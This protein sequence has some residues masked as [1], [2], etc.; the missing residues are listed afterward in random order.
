[1]SHRVAILGSGIGAQ[2]LDGYLA[3]P[4]R[5]TV[6]HV[7]DLN[8][9]L[10]RA[11]AARVPG[12]V[13]SQ[14]IAA[15]LADPAVEIVD[16]C[17]PP[18]MHVPVTC[19]ALAAGKHV[20]CEKP[21]AGSVA[22]ADR[23]QQ[24]ASRSAGCLVFPVFQ[25]RFG[26]AF[27]ALAALGQAGLLGAPRVASLETHWNRDATYYAVPWRGTWDRE[28]GGAVLS[29][30]IHI[31]DL[32]GQCFGPIAEV[33]AMLGTMINP[34][35]TEDCAAIALRMENGALVTSSIT[36]G[37]ASDTSRLRLVYE[38]LSVESGRLPYTPAQ[39]IWTFTARDPAKQ[40]DVDAVVS[41][42]YAGDGHVG[43]A[44]FLA[45]VADTLDGP[46]PDQAVSLADGS[47]A[48]ELVSA[49]YYSDYTG[50]RVR[51]PLDRTLPICQS[52]VRP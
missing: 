12:A 21:I 38:H 43:F 10:A 9:E 2:H 1:M 46:K 35:E 44:G 40:A 37:A 4:G 33:S 13:S 17:L 47:G 41:G 36:L 39:D 18:A 8:R 20:I 50:E 51:L 6:S 28:M 7:C 22:D 3:L 49:I 48:I 15:I 26:P 27:D 23:L 34:I 24:A 11:Q 42:A 30:A 29:H 25:Y 16:I 19:D 32:I 5:F 31:H 52:L 14:D 45:S